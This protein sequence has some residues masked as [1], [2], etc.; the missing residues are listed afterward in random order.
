M[1]KRHKDLIFWDQDLLNIY[2][3]SN[4]LELSKN[5]NYNYVEKDSLKNKD[6]IFL[7][8]AGKISLGMFKML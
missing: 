7:H 4:Y 5:L 6:I 3:D 2:L 1:K 8:Y